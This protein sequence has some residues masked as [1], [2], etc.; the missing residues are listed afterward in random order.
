MTVQSPNGHTPVGTVKYV[1]LISDDGFEY[2][3]PRAAAATSGTLRRMLN[4]KGRCSVCLMIVENVGLPVANFSCAAG[5]VESRESRC[6]L[7]SMKYLTLR[8]LPFSP[9]LC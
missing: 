2:I 8:P 9:F 4:P 7:E 1:T 5:F 6:T 3:I